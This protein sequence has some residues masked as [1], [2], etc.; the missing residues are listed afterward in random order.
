MLCSAVMPI[1]Y[2]IPIPAAQWPPARPASRWSTSPGRLR[3]DHAAGPSARSTLAKAIQRPTPPGVGS[4]ARRALAIVR[5]HPDGR[6]VDAGYGPNPATEGASTA[7]ARGAENCRRRVLVAMIPEFPAP[8]VEALIHRRVPRTVRA[9]G[10]SATACS[11]LRAWQGGRRAASW[12][13]EHPCCAC[14]RARA[15]LAIRG[16]ATCSLRESRAEGLGADR[17]CR[18]RALRASAT[19]SVIACWR[20]Q[21]LDVASPTACS[22]STRLRAVRRAGDTP[23]RCR[24]ARAARP[25]KNFTFELGSAAPPTNIVLRLR[26]WGCSG[27]S[28]PD[29]QIPADTEGTQASISAWKDQ[30]YIAD[31]YALRGYP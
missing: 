11:S 23:P 21:D 17:Q 15:Q 10:R 14:R 19:S 2:G 28:A 13:R 26:P 16:A 24:S 7:S 6:A 1:D 4:V 9:A 25:A 29:L 27:C 20:P 18:L 12:A 31:L 5:H 22:T 3:P 30:A 8:V